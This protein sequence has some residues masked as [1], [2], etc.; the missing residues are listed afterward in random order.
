MFLQKKWIEGLWYFHGERDDW[1]MGKQEV[2]MKVWLENIS[3]TIYE[4]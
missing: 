3:G 1:D 4:T 2:Q